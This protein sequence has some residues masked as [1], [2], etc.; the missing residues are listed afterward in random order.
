MIISASRRTDI[1]AFLGAWF[2][3]RLRAGS[4]QVANP[5]NP[6][7]VSTLSLRRRDVY[8]F[9]FWTKDPAPFFERLAMLDERQDRYYFLFTLNAYGRDLEPG[10]PA[11]DARI[12]SFLRLSDRLG[13]QRVCWRYDPIVLSNRTDPD[14]HRRAFERLCAALEGHTRRVIISL[15]TYYRK[16]DRR[17]RG[18]EQ[19]G[20]HFERDVAQ[21]GKATALLADLAAMANARGVQMQSCA[22]EW[23]FSAAGIP[24]GAC[25]DADLIRA[26]WG[27]E[28]DGTKDPGQRPHC[29]CARSRD[30]GTNGTC[31]H[32]CVYCYANR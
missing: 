30:I 18:L 32:G 25:I 27:I 6:R 14:F 19:Q 2:A 10:L 31:G 4:V 1:P 15:L 26:I 3:E 22:S 8:A 13:P 20:V 7:Q 24:A 11:L 17:L 29:L 28:L 21:S 5:F 9:V 12:G 16:V 23:D